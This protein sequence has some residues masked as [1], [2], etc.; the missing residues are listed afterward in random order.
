MP[1]ASDSGGSLRVFENGAGER[2]RAYYERMVDPRPLRPRSKAE[3]LQRRSVV[4]R[5][6]LEALAL[7]P[8]PERLPLD[9]REGGM[10]ERE[11]YRVQ[12]LY[13]QTWP[14][15]WASGWLYTPRDTD[16]KGPAVLNPHGH[17]SEGARH[18][19]VQSRMIALAKLG[20]LALAVDSAHVY[21][22]A[23][24]VSPLTVMTYNNLRA[25]DY[26]AGRPDV[27]R[28][29]L[30]ITGESGGAQQAMYLLA[31]DDRI[32]TA[33]LAV[34]VSYFK[35]ILMP[36]G[37]HCP[38][39]HVP[40]IMRFTDEPEL[41]AVASPRALLYLTVTGDWTA[42]FPDHELGELLAVYRLWQQPDRL[43]HRQFP[44]P[45]DYS[46]EMREAAYTWFER[47]LRG[48]RSAEAVPEPV[49]QVEEPG[50]LATL[51]SP[52]E[53]D[54]GADGVI[55]WYRKRVVAQPPQLESRQSRKSYQEGLRASLALLLGEEPESVTLETEWHG[56]A[57]A[58]ETQGRL[59]SFRTERDVRIP[60]VWLPPDGGAPHPV[61]I[62]L[63]PEGKDAAL[64][65]VLVEG[66]RQAGHAVLAPDVRLRGE[67]HREWLHNTLIWG[68]P[69]AGMAARDVRACVDWLMEREE[70]DWGALTVLGEGD[71]GLVALLAAALDERV[72]C[73]LADCRG[74]TY[75]DGGEGLP[76]I[77]NI[78][79]VADVPQIGGL[80][81]PRPLWLYGVPEERV[82]FP[83]RRYYDWTRRTYQS[84]GEPDSLK[85]STYDTPEP[86]ALVDWLEKRGRKAK[87]R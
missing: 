54:L 53:G 87:R 12:R 37:H 25:L 81:A 27:D 19:G 2:L 82:G 69:E 56:P 33:V 85:M 72:T 16:G 20:Y 35:R 32:R 80:V 75:R 58:R 66:A 49:L 43:G 62:A 59:V 3:W 47:E 4:R 34:L 57:G 73:V 68:R 36:E 18:P 14:Q 17:W 71:Q 13:W 83:S 5:Q 84:L 51:D 26:L 61:M 21:D 44:G 46:H 1:G 6:T 50:T 15:V 79:R 24:G 48:I 63:H 39:N 76:V 74:T 78:L 64:R 29:R 86:A 52:P 55:Q 10:L 67:M 11:G 9:V 23:T 7:S 28:E 8:L 30:G 22:Y 45:H 41:C 38:C 77:P 31:V 40:G 65:S 70:V 60:A 42:P